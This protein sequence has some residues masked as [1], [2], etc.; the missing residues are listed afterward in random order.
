MDEADGRGRQNKGGEL[1]LQRSDSTVHISALPTRIGEERST[2]R[3]TPNERKQMKVVPS[4]ATA[5]M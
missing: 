4:L 2:L 3:H 5:G 1:V